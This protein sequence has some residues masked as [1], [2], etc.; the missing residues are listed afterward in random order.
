[1][2]MLPYRTSDNVIDGLV[3]TF[4]YHQ[5][6]AVRADAQYG[7]PAVP[8]EFCGQPARSSSDAEY[9]LASG[10]GQSPFVQTLQ[11]QHRSRRTTFACA[12]WRSPERATDAPMARRA[13]RAQD[14]RGGYGHCVDA[15][16]RWAEGVALHAHRLERRGE[17]PGLILLALRKELTMKNKK[18]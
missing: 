18:R 3:L 14:D 10:I 15:T 5:T 16:R 9:R 4:G 12:E 6:E 17:L 2:R 7:C 13:G 1:M 11:L 8:G